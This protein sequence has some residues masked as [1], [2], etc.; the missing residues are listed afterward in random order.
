MGK[1][2][3]NTKY[4]L[5]SLKVRDSLVDTGVDGRMVLKLS[6]PN[7]LGGNEGQ[8]GYRWQDVVITETNH[9]DL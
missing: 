6:L 9:M 1:W 2:E 5:G 3:S 8:G 7:R 4:L